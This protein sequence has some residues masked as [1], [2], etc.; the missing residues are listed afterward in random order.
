MS[1]PQV[2]GLGAVAPAATVAIILPDTGVVSY[3]TL[4]GI[5]LVAIATII[6]VIRFGRS[7]ITK[8]SSK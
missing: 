2:L 1:S 7:L 3:F 4:L 6:F 5:A 8:F